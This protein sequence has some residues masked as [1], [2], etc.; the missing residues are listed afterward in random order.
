ML[1]NDAREAANFPQTILIGSYVTVSKTYG[2]H[3]RKQKPIFV[4]YETR[5]KTGGAHFEFQY[6]SLFKIEY[7]NSL[8]V[9]ISRDAVFFKEYFKYL[10]PTE[11]PNGGSRFDGCGINFYTKEQ[12]KTMSDSIAADKPKEYEVLLAWLEK[13]ILAQDCKG[14]YILGV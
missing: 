3:M 10:E 6:C 2:A 4:S 12:A 14:F 13:V 5:Q 9:P 1:S 8:F 7:E 11:T